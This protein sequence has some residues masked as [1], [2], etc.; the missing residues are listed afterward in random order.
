[1]RDREADRDEGAD[2]S[3]TCASAVRDDV[4][5]LKRAPHETR[6]PRATQAPEML[7]QSTCGTTGSR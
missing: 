1:M 5:H 3:V 2:A 6:W 7:G 4:A